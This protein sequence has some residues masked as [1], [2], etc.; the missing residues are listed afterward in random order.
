MPEASK[1]ERYVDTRLS[2]YQKWYDR[3]AVKMKAMHLR[4]R[5]VSV[6]GGAMVPVLVN[7]DLPFA[8]LTATALSLVVVGSVSLESVYRYRE[9]WKN[10]RSTEQLLGHEKVYFQSGVGPYLGLSESESFTTLVAR[11]EKAIANENSATLNVMTLGGQVSADLQPADV[12]PPR[13]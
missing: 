10:Y 7:I 12:T 2:Q 5:T 11:V 4:M 9:Q 8:R 1:A 3:K 13:A 6:V